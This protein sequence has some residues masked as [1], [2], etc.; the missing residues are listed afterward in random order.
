MTDAAYNAKNWLMR[1]NEIEERRIKAANKKAFI[2]AKLNSCV[3]CYEITGHRDQIGARA[4]H[5]DLLLDYS[6]ACDELEKITRQVMYAD[7][8]TIE[9]LEKVQPTIYRVVLICRYINRI[10][11]IQM[12]R[13][14]KFE[15]K[16]TQLYEIEKRALETL[17]GI[18]EN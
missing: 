7:H 12:V 8:V 1:T 3:S 2:E 6:I 18:L 9:E 16:R 10:T 11:I 15:Y 17:G 13:S 5:E 14:G 4:A